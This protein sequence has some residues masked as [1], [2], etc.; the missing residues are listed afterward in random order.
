MKHKWSILLFAAGLIILAYP[1]IAQLV[2]NRIQHNQ[3]DE[4]RTALDD[5]PDEEVVRLIDRAREYNEDIAEESTGLRDPW[6]DQEEWINAYRDLGFDDNEMFGALEIPKL[7]VRTPIYL[8]SSEAVLSKGVGQVEGS[9]LPLGGLGTHTVLAGHRGMPTIPMFRD[10]DRLQAG[11][12]FFIHTVEETLEYRVVAQEVIYPDDTDSLEIQD[13]RDLA[14]LLTCHPY[15][16]NYQ[17][18]LVHGER[19]E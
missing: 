12:V 10:L 11:D 2:N 7:N 17:R 4:F 6:G 9:S 19:V 5:L 14:T 8:G 18:L 1:H 15:R 16:H 3:V 13:G